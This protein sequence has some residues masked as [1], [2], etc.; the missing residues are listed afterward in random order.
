MTFTDA[1]LLRP[2]LSV[3]A[4]PMPS[5]HPTVHPA[6]SQV[7]GLTETLN[8][9]RRQYKSATTNVTTLSVEI[10]SARASPAQRSLTGSCD[11]L[12]KLADKDI[13]NGKFLH[14]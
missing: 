5:S 7:T 1:L 14:P 8:Q 11:E 9:A 10:H 13:K 12:D 3:P 2:W 6:P 4:V